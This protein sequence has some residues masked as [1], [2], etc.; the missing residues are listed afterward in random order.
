MRRSVSLVAHR[1]NNS[2]FCSPRHI[3][4]CVTVFCFFF[5]YGFCFFALLLTR[6]FVLMCNKVMRRRQKKKQIE[7]NNFVM[8]LSVPIRAGWEWENAAAAAPTPHRRRCKHTTHLANLI[9]PPV[10]AKLTSNGAPRPKTV[11]KCQRQ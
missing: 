1:N 3:P 10:S 9:F 6:A 4:V 8:L 5:I 7:L 11:S 2:S